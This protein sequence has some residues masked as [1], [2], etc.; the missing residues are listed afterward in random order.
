MLAALPNGKQ[1][2]LVKVRGRHLP[3]ARRKVD[4]VRVVHL[5]EVVEAAALLRVGQGVS[6]T[7]V[8][9]GD[10]PLLLRGNNPIRQ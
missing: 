2:D 8:V 5:G 9:D 10:V 4:I 6:A 1:A 3:C 7:V